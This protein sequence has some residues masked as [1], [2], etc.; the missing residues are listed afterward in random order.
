MT[1]NDADFVDISGFEGRYQINRLGEV[2]SLL[3]NR[4]LKPHLEILKKNGDN[5]Y[6]RV[7]LN[8]YTGKKHTKRIHRLLAET[9]LP[10]PENLPCVDHIN[11]IRIDNRLENLQW[12]S[13]RHNAINRVPLRLQTSK[14][15]YN[16]KYIRDHYYHKKD[17]T[18][19]QKYRIE[20]MIDSKLSIKRLFDRK[21]GNAEE[22]NNILLVRNILLRKYCPERFKYCRKYFDTN[23]K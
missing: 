9:F 14:K 7:Y 16:H 6:Y 4:L 21:Y 23:I 19:Q 5:K 17:G 15:H 22:Y 13:Q 10:N 18:L 11:N 12:V 2:H 20:F 8:D 1:V 3:S